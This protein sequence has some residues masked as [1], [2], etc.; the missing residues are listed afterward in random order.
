MRVE[1]CACL[2]VCLYAWCDL[3]LRYFMVAFFAIR[4]VKTTN[5]RQWGHLQCRFVWAKE[6]WCVKPFQPIHLHFA[7]VKVSGF[8]TWP[9]FSLTST[10]NSSFP[11]RKKNFFK[12][13]FTLPSVQVCLQLERKFYKAHL[14][15]VLSKSLTD[16]RCKT[17][18]H[19]RFSHFQPWEVSLAKVSQVSNKK[20]DKEK[21]ECLSKSTFPP[22][23]RKITVTEKTLPIDWAVLLGSYRRIRQRL[24]G[25]NVEMYKW[26]LF[27]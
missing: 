1:G 26:A 10:F 22:F 7:V 18:V 17:A 2:S 9:F 8:S 3:A 13:A 20:V 23:C 21:R 12:R 11:N 25:S 19:W 15:L 5:F 24:R 27:R 14:E 6:L 16:K 4:Y